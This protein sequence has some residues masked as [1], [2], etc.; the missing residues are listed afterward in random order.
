MFHESRITINH[1]HQ[2]IKYTTLNKN[3]I[4]RTRIF[5]YYAA[6]ILIVV[7][8]FQS[9]RC[10]YIGEL[11]NDVIRLLEMTSLSQT[12]WRNAAPLYTTVAFHSVI[13]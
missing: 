10:V 4:F 8:N 5:T 3:S 1:T 7:G 11:L 12:S 9:I 2:K 13:L 6:L